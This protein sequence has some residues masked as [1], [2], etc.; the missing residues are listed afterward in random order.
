MTQFTY[1]GRMAAYTDTQR[2]SKEIAAVDLLLLLT[3]AIP[4][5]AGVFSWVAGQVAEFIHCGNQA[6]KC[7]D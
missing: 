5:V 2:S 4:P 6:A 7:A 1:P 3:P